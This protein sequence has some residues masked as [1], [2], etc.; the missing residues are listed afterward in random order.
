MIKVEDCKNWHEMS[1]ARGKHCFNCANRNGFPY[2]AQPDKNCSKFERLLTPRAAD[3][4]CTCAKPSWV[5]DDGNTF[6]CSLCGKTP[7]R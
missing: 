6:Y 2:R 4:A 7:R 1:M 3:G 5:H